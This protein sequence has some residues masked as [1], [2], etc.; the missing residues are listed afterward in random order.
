MLTVAIIL[1][2]L[3]LSQAQSVL[4]ECPFFPGTCPMNVDNIIDVMYH[5]IIDDFSCQSECR[6]LEDCNYFTMFGATT[7]LG[8][9]TKKCFLFKSCDHIIDCPPEFDDCITGEC[10]SSV[11]RE[12]SGFLL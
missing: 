9:P 10:L 6:A 2:F 4:P 11:I 7:E 12:H 5:D 8:E 1:S 3:A